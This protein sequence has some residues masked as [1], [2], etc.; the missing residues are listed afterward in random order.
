[1]P[2]LTRDIEVYFVKTRILISISQGLKKRPS[3]I[4][5]GI[6]YSKDT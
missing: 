2:A 1:M 4:N 6:G 5:Q 3:S